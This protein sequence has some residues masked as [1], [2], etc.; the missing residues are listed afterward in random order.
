MKRNIYKV[1]FSAVLVLM[2]I[3]ST[4]STA[5]AETVQD[6]LENYLNGAV[7]DYE[8]AETE[9][10]QDSIQ[11]QLDAWLAENGFDSIDL[12]AITDTDIGSIVSGLM[13]GGGSSIFDSI[14]GAFGD[15]GGLI[16]DAFNSGIGMITDVIGG[17]PGTSDGSNTATT[18]PV[19]SPNIIIADDT[20]KPESSTHAV[21]V[22]N[23]QAPTTQTATTTEP[24]ASEVTTYNVGTN[25]Q[26]NIISSGVTTTAPTTDSVVEDDDSSAVTLLIVLSATTIAIIVGIVV[27]FLNKRNRY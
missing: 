18:E 10:E 16:S 1:L 4:V 13:G 12:G 22:P 8:S 26:G 20:T 17:G 11:E 14:T 15:L 2:L 23:I 9:E 6:R 25:V 19:T 7:D 5:F 3:F 24:V 27:F 21:G